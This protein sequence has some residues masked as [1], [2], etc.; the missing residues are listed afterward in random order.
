MHSHPLFFSNYIF[1]PSL[2]ALM[3]V[4][5]NQNRYTVQYLE[6]TL[7]APLHHEVPPCPRADVEPCDRKKYV[8]LLVAGVTSIGHSRHRGKRWIVCDLRPASINVTV[9]EKQKT[10]AHGQEK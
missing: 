6:D 1:A 4:E 7:G 5:N 8:Q 9:E 3:S 10:R 2:E